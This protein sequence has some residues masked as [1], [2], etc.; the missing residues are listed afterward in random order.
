MN[1]IVRVELLE[2]PVFVH[3]R[4]SEHSQGLQRE[5]QL[6]L[7][8]SAEHALDAP[9]RL[10]DLIGQVNSQYGNLSGPQN[11]AIEAAAAR[12]DETIDRLE[13]Q[14]PVGVADA[15]IRLNHALD[16]ADDFCRRGDGLLT[17]A[18]PDEAVAYRRWFLGE[19]VAQAGGLEPLAWTEADQ[20]ALLASPRLRGE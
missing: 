7:I 20:A 4:A 1:D 10:L 3:L 18:T 12:N 15:C 19:F 9:R 11:D 17:L 16:E 6:V 8:G 5:F 13:W 14:V 2:F